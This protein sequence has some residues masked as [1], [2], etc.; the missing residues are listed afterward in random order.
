M[1]WDFRENKVYALLI[2]F[3]FCCLHLKSKAKPDILFNKGYS[4]S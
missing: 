2:A 3:R 4:P 1:L